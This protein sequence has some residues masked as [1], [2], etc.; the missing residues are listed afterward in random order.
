MIM[1]AAEL[2]FMPQNSLVQGTAGCVTSPMSSQCGYIKW[3]VIIIYIARDLSL[4]TLTLS[5]ALITD[6]SMSSPTRLII[7]IPGRKV[8]TP[9]QL[10]RLSTWQGIPGQR[11]PSSNKENSPTTSLGGGDIVQQ[12]GSS[13]EI[14]GLEMPRSK[15][16]RV[17]KD[18]FYGKMA[19][20]TPRL[21]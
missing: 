16:P 11:T 17:F 15:K 8:S 20:N 1:S 3:C 21:R 6:F 13:P 10:S 5:L 12:C 7:R 18:V 14:P 9:N 4:T 19:L 2:I